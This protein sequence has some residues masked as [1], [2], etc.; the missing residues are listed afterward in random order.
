MPYW[1]K[2]RGWSFAEQYLFEPLGIESASWMA[3]WGGWA[4]IGGVQSMRPRDMAKVG[5]L[6]LQNGNWN[7]EQIISKDWIQLSMQEHVTLEP[8]QQ[9]SWEQGY[10]YLWWLGNVRIIG[11]HV[12]T[13]CALGDGSK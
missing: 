9:P 7:G 5:L 10:G 3:F 4:E 2:R 8:E 12:K 1:P 6:V 11:S 13:V